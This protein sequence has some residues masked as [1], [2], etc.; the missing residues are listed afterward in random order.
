[1]NVILFF[2]IDIDMIVHLNQELSENVVI[3]WSQY[4]RWRKMINTHNWLRIV[5]VRPD[6]LR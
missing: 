5:A 4:I 6:S 1:M 2:D 3:S